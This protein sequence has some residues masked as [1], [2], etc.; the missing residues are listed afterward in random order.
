MKPNILFVD[1]EQGILN[2]LRLALRAKRGQW[3]MDFALGGKEALEALEKTI[4]N[5]V[6]TDMRMPGLDGAQVLDEA[7]RLQPHC[8]RVILSGY[9]DSENVLKAVK[10]AHLY[11]SKPCRSDVLAQT[12]EKALELDGLLGDASLRRVAARLESLPALPRCYLE[13][14]EALGREDV[15]L[16]RIGDIINQDA[17][18][19]ATI[20]R[21]V[22]S[23][24]FGLPQRV[25]SL[26]HAVNLLGEQTLRALVLTVHLFT[27]LDPGHFP[28]F[29]VPLLW[30]H[31]FRVGCLAKAIAQ[32][33]GAGQE[34]REDCFIAGMLHDVGKLVLLTG[35]PQDY[36]AVVARVRTDGLS[37]FLAEQSALAASHA[38]VGGYLLNLWGFAQPVLEA[39]CRHH[40]PGVLS[41]ETFSATAAVAAANHL[42][43]ALVRL[44]PDYGV[45]PLGGNDEAS[46]LAARRLETWREV[47]RRTLEGPAGTDAGG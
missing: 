46:A 5:V 21:L 6:V 42:D 15:P 39:V 10:P 34:T 33:E 16:S 25:A 9:A 29:S 3:N 38:A 45:H 12:L 2:G 31:S 40:D 32:A 47:C 14:Q 41:E 17:G 27:T 13:L 28:D 20:L 35:L 22:N 11:L 19:A 1:D 7:K 8:V 23:A 24:F 4:Y 18:M 44:H 37:L 30:E 36:A 26:H 43:H